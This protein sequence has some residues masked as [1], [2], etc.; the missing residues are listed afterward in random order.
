MTDHRIS[1]TLYNLEQV[2]AGDIDGLLGPLK[3]QNK[4]TLLNQME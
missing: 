3:K 2:M 1:L 4:E